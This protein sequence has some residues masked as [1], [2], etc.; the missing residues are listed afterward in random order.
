[1]TKKI[2]ITCLCLMF[3]AAC[4][5]GITKE[6]YIDAMATLGCKG[7]NEGTP[8]SEAIFKEKK[9]TLQGVQDFRKKGKAEDML[10]AS[11]E[12]ANRVMACH[13]L[14]PQN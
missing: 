3:L 6:Q 11:M 1:M 10:K 7:V 12:I 2:V 14:T 8:E 9:I 13:G 5:R 4:S